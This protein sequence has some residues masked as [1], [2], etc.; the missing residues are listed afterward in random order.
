[1]STCD[2]LDKCGFFQKHQKSSWA[3]CQGF[4]TLYCQG[5]KMEECKRKAYRKEHGAPPPDD[6]L[7]SGQMIK[8]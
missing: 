2:L 7:P 8:G 3:A 4:I 1:M 6:L 5:P